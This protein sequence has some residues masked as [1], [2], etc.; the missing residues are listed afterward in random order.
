MK[1]LNRLFVVALLL[2]LA[3]CANPYLSRQGVQAQ[4]VPTAPQ[5]YAFDVTK[6]G[7][8]IDEVIRIPEQRYWFFQILLIFPYYNS[9]I[10]DIL[11]N[12][13]YGPVEVN[14]PISIQ[15]Y[16]ID[17][18]GKENLIHESIKETDRC[19]AH[20]WETV[21]D[22]EVIFEKNITKLLLKPGV[23]RFKATVLR[24]N[25]A[26]QNFRSGFTVDYGPPM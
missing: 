9:T 17:A 13:C 11:D 3:A 8:T 4:S 21:I 7:T 1:H 24:D 22:A 10:G 15:V 20:H 25:T 12:V 26:I 16:S 19:Y 6:Q 23:Y 2:S 14:I 18:D 5:R